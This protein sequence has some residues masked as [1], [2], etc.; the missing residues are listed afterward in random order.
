MK[1]LFNQVYKRNKLYKKFDKKQRFLKGNV[2]TNINVYTSIFYVVFN[3][4]N[5]GSVFL[6]KS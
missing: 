3:L 4:Q 5:I 1:T 2:H 6:M